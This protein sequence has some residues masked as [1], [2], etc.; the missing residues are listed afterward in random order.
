MIRTQVSRSRS[1]F[2]ARI[3]FQPPSEWAAIAAQRALAIVSHLRSTIQLPA[4]SIVIASSLKTSGKRANLL[5]HHGPTSSWNH[6]SVDSPMKS[7]ESPHRVDMNR[8][9][10]N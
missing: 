9:Q 1:K 3:W 7:Q 10:A 8:R 5:L 6:L 4:A 2:F